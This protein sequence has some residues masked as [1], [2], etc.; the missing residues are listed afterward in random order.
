VEAKNFV[1]AFNNK[2]APYVT[3][4]ISSYFETEC[5]PKSSANFHLFL[6]ADVTP[7]NIKEIHM[8]VEKY[9]GRVFEYFVDEAY[10]YEI[11]M[12]HPKRSSWAAPTFYHLMAHRFLPE[13]VHRAL[14]IDV[15][16]LFCGDISEFYN[17]DISDCAVMVCDKK[18]NNYDEL[19][20]KEKLFAA[21]ATRFAAFFNGGVVMLNLDYLRSNSIDENYYRN[22]ID[23]YVNYCNEQKITNARVLCEQ[24]L[25]EF[26]FWDK[27]LFKNCRTTVNA[28][29]S[30]M[31]V[32]NDRRLI[33]FMAYP[34]PWHIQASRN[35][36][37]HR[38]LASNALG[39]LQ[40]TAIRGFELWWDAARNT[41]NYD[42]ILSKESDWSGGYRMLRKLL[43]SKLGYGAV[44][45]EFASYR[46]SL[47]EQAFIGHS[48][49][50]M[51]FRGGAK[52]AGGQAVG[53]KNNNIKRTEDSLLTKFESDT[54]TRSISLL[55]ALQTP[56]CNAVKY[57]LSY[58]LFVP[59]SKG[60]FA[61]IEFMAI[62]ADIKQLIEKTT[63]T[64]LCVENDVM[65]EIQ[66]SNEKTASRCSVV[67]LSARSS[68]S[69]IKELDIDYIRIEEL[70]AVPGGGQHKSRID[71]KPCVVFAAAPRFFRNGGAA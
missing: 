49:I 34:K 39:N 44:N 58:K 41:A 43:S 38:S 1:L 6:T 50:V 40:P 13:T 28:S 5:E 42:R 35:D 19:C 31:D 52:Y 60:T 15:D 70:K 64:H 14:H 29:T 48:D 65:F 7:E 67:Q 51:D 16:M 30:N 24:V 36:A 46:L 9:G 68:R 71:R 57:R 18:P 21:Q 3:V 62:G 45:F 61:V 56:L 37:Y 22:E 63:N 11:F 17:T 25:I 20:I 47:L 23:A 59:E 54:P 32:P 10:Y 53:T 26:C 69:E 27:L 4:V 12:N 8:T 55:F 66:S 33:H 2:I